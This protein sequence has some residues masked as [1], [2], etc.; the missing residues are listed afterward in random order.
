MTRPFLDSEFDEEVL[1]FFYKLAAHCS[2]S[3]VSQMMA[4]QHCLR[5]AEVTDDCL[6]TSVTFPIMG[7]S[8][9]TGFITPTPKKLSWGR[10]KE[11][12]IKLDDLLT[13]YEDDLWGVKRKSSVKKIH[14]TRGIC[15]VNLAA[16]ES[17]SF[18]PNRGEMH[19][20]FRKMFHLCVTWIV[21][22]KVFS[23]KRIQFGTFSQTE[24]S[25]WTAKVP[26]SVKGLI[27]SCVVIPCSYDYPNPGNTLTGFTGIWTEV[28]TSQVIYHP[29]VSKIEGPYRQRTE[30]LGDI[31]QK[32]C[33][34]KIDPLKSS[35]HGP[36]VFR[37]E[38]KDYNRF[39]YLTN[40]VTIT[41][42]NAP[43]PVSFSVKEEVKAGEA[44]SASCSVTHSCPAVPPTFTWSHSEKAHVQH[45]L[46][47]GGQWKTTS[48][49]SFHP[50][51]ADHNKPL[52]C[53]VTYSGGQT[54][55]KSMKLRVKY[56]P[57]NVKVQYKSDV[58]EGEFVRLK[59]SSDA[60]PPAGSYEWHNETGAKLHQGNVFELNVSRH[61]TGG[62]YCTANNTEGQGKSEPVQFN[63]SY[64]PEVNS[65]SSCSVNGDLV[66]CTCIV[67]SK[68]PSMIHFLLSDKILPSTKTEKNGSFTIGTLQAEF[69]SYT[70]VM[71]LANN[72]QGNATL[73]LPVNKQ[74]DDD[75]HW[76]AV[77][78]NDTNAAVY[79]NIE[80]SFVHLLIIYTHREQSD[81]NLISNT[82]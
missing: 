73:M 32:N 19:F 45:Q 5:E 59:C 33:S 63:V 48:T 75:A 13:Q 72:T 23:L 40:K 22:V 28:S 79:G 37:I 42:N 44:V 12:T 25:S 82:E 20:L 62:L 6:Q 70:F 64:A 41:T 27:G 4:L 80:V 77:Y 39:S 61:H 18:Y 55:H 30:L 31:S 47:E 68:P 3:H 35:D 1:P 60:H 43:D 53:S 49:L 38:I 14:L 34:L 17:V 81:F 52:N 24:A 7:N 9:S 74:Y 26:S 57:L 76:S 78:I 65:T 69:G 67:A 16:H 66:K 50:T 8:A 54:Q 58:K 10:Q 21:V 2:F 36:F 51:S 56:A 71:C 11:D 46:L 29:E 15:Y